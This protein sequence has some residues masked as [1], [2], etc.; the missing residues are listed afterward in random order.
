MSMKE[1]LCE[2]SESLFSTKGLVQT[3]LHSLP[4]LPPPPPP[5]HPNQKRNPP[6]PGFEPT[7]KLSAPD[8]LQYLRSSSA[9][10]PVAPRPTRLVD[11]TI[12]NNQP[13]ETQPSEPLRRFHWT[14]ESG[15]TSCFALRPNVTE[16]SDHQRDIL[17]YFELQPLVTNPVTSTSTSGRDVTRTAF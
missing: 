6:T 8:R 1:D 17:C 10:C 14:L 2:E 4:P 5:P 15:E 11:P 13:K 3:G 9:P 7:K 12:S 16:D